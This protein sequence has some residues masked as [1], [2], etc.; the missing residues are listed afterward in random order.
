MRACFHAPRTFLKKII[1][2]PN[3]F[4]NCNCNSASFLLYFRGKRQRPQNFVIV[5]P[6][7]RWVGTRD[8]TPQLTAAHQHV[9][10]CS[11]STQTRHYQS[12]MKVI[13]LGSTGFIGR[14]VFHQCLK[15][16][17]I[18]SLIALSRRDLPEAAVNPKLTVVIIDDFKNYPGSVLE[19]LKDADAC[20]W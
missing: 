5:V 13:L 1:F 20:I 9:R 16:P 8:L 12:K 17:A 6:P 18:T 14:E 4:A 15:D 2:Q 11:C 3:R 10:S 7:F 19:Q